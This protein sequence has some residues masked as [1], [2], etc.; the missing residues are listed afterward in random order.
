MADEGKKAREA[1]QD[2]EVKV[3]AVADLGC[4]WGAL[5]VDFTNKTTHFGHSMDHG[6]RNMGA[7]AVTIVKDWFEACGTPCDGWDYE[8]LHVGQQGH[9]SGSCGISAL[10]AIECLL[11][12]RTEGWEKGRSRHHRMRYLRLLTEPAEVCS[13]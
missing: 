7:T 6:A 3:F 2:K 4:H 9:E 13:T 5:C 10:N 1:N 12:P 8:R 11:D